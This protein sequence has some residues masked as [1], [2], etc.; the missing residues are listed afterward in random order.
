MPGHASLACPDENKHTLCQ[1]S[2]DVASSTVGGMNSK[3]P[4]KPTSCLVN[5]HMLNQHIGMAMCTPH[6]T[7]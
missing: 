2:N 1:H 6:R 5:A 4:S 3:H 7:T